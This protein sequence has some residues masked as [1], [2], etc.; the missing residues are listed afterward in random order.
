MCELIRPL[1]NC[2][3]RLDVKL[4]LALGDCLRTRG[5][6]LKNADQHKATGDNDIAA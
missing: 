3:M 5:G 1:Q 4:V 6:K 2:N